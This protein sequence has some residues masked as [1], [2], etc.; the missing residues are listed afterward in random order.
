MKVSLLTAALIVLLAQ[1]VSA[2]IKPIVWSESIH[3]TPKPPTELVNLDNYMILKS[4]R[5]LSLNLTDNFPIKT[6]QL[7][8]DDTRDSHMN[9][10][11]FLFNIELSSKAKQVVDIPFGEHKFN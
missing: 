4:D 2:E 6:I 10:K 1:S 9:K 7:R 11:A 8:P 5:T 3:N